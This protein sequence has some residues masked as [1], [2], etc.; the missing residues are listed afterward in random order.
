MSNDSFKKLFNSHDSQIINHCQYYMFCLP[1]SYAIDLR[2][3]E[4]YAYLLSSGDFLLRNL[5]V[6][7]C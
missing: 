6:K 7:F 3:A 5:F 2:A 1:T 4:L